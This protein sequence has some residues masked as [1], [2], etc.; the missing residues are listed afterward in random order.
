MVPTPKNVYTR[1]QRS[2]DSDVV[3][4]LSNLQVL[5]AT[6]VA[7]FFGTGIETIRG[8]L[9]RLVQ[10]A[11]T[12]PGSTKQRALKAA[13]PAVVSVLEGRCRMDSVDC[14]LDVVYTDQ[15]WRLSRRAARAIAALAIFTNSLGL[16]LDG[17]LEINTRADMLLK[18]IERRCADVLR[19]L[20]E[21]YDVP[22][23]ELVPDTAHD[24]QPIQ[25]TT[26][27]AALNVCH[28]EMTCAVCW[29]VWE[30]SKAPEGTGTTV[31]LDTDITR[32]LFYLSPTLT[33][34]RHARVLEVPPLY[35]LDGEFTHPI[36]LLHRMAE[37]AVSSVENR[38][39]AE[40]YLREIHGNLVAMIQARDE[41]PV[42]IPPIAW[43][44]EAA[45]F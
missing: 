14:S 27:R 30:A 4:A 13:L 6:R 40:P 7:A 24:T 12:G 36:T 2:Q 16:E 1:A 22:T 23:E 9:R 21:Q 33:T 32:A 29:H 15:H 39:V 44:V 35:R 19:N 8:D 10:E 45:T 38:I 11:T 20:L 41:R 43:G 17:C 42:H 31:S 5:A 37:R 26:A 28:A 34:I 3:V 25:T 18:W